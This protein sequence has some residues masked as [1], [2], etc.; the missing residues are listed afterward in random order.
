MYGTAAYAPYAG[1]RDRARSLFGQTMGLVAVTTA[2]FAGGAYAGRNL[3]HG[4]G[5]IAFIAAF[6]VLLIMHFAARRSPGV[7]TALLLA[8]GV[9]LGVASSPTL[10]YYAR[11]DP[12]VLWQAGTR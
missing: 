1:T 6:V 9:L 11:A 3:S 8:F 12:Q 2:V 4:V 7:A 5:I 10:V